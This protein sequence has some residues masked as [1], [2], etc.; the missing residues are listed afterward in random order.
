MKDVFH[1]FVRKLHHNIYL[2][3][4]VHVHVETHC[5]HVTDQKTRET[6]EF[7][8]TRWLSDLLEAI[9]QSALFTLEIQVKITGV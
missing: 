4:R 8:P 1:T 3:Y 9:R 6:L 2:L 5:F 7:Y